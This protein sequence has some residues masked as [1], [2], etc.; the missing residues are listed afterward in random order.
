M[1]RVCWDRVSFQ[2][3]LVVEL[4]VIC[5]RLLSCVSNVSLRAAVSEPAVSEPPSA[6]RKCTCWTMHGCRSSPQDQP[7]DRYQW[8]TSAHFTAKLTKMAIAKHRRQS[9]KPFHLQLLRITS[10][11]TNRPLS[12]CEGQGRP[13]CLRR[14]FPYFRSMSEPG[15]GSGL[16]V[17]HQA[18]SI[19]SFSTSFTRRFSR[20]SME[21]TGGHFGRTDRLTFTSHPT[22]TKFKIVLLSFSMP[23]CT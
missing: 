1:V 18:D 4:K 12:G 10:S 3:L 21:S 15:S 13:S 5:R 8:T 2:L 23:Y 9:M 19:S 17:D 6:E 16:R 20:V 7:L 14:I 22:P 11:S